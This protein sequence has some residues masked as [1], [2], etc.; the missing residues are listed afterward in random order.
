MRNLRVIEALPENAEKGFSGLLYTQPNFLVG[1]NQLPQKHFY[2]FDSSANVGLGHIGFS[3]EEGIFFSPFKAPFGGFSLADD[4][5]SIEITFFI[6]E[7]IRILKERGAAFIQIKLA[8]DCYFK[9][10][11]VLVENLGYAGF[12]LLE[13][14]EY[15]AIPIIGQEFD[16]TLASMEIRKLKKCKDAGFQ[17]SKLPKHKLADVFEFIKGQRQEKGYRFSMEWPQLKLAQ[18]V[19]P[20]AYIPFVVKDKDRIVAATIGILASD[21]VLYNFSPAHHPEYEQLSPVVLLTEGLYDFCR[22]SEL[23]YLDLGTSYLSGKVNEGLRQFK[24]HLGGQS[25]FSYSFRKAV[26]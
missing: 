18:K 21:K 24:S 8:P 14:L 17:F 10:M 23:N 1:N 12:E 11:G 5:T 2:L 22:A 19:N 16:A 13:R 9:N 3:L 26:S 20:D 25:F 7:V 4:L 15:Q 6:F